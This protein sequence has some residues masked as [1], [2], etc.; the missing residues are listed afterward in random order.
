MTTHNKRTA[1]A[2]SRG[3]Y[4]YMQLLSEF[5]LVMQTFDW[6]QDAACRGRKD[7]DF[8]PE[9][10]YNGKAPQA[11]RLCHIC[12]V[13]EDCLDFAIV[14]DIDYGIWGGTNPRERR[15]LRRAIEK[16]TVDL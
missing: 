9:I 5:S 14:N 3:N 10:G 16:G 13:R 12:P 11:V 4:D 7:V 8:F 15:S 2:G 6:M 1:T